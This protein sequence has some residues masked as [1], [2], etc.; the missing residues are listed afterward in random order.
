MLQQLR[1]PTCGTRPALLHAARV[2][3]RWRRVLC[4]GLLKGRL[5]ERG[6]GRQHERKGG[7]ALSTPSE[8]CGSCIW[9]K[10]GARRLQRARLCAC[11]GEGWSTPASGAQRRDEPASIIPMYLPRGGLFTHC[12]TAW[13]AAGSAEALGGVERQLAAAVRGTGLNLPAL[14]VIPY[15]HH[16]RRRGWHDDAHVCS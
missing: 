1:A 12:Y 5:K 9:Q 11:M 4:V 13:E 15:C 8:V 2:R 14:S 7:A 16:V 10:R 6:T 3:R